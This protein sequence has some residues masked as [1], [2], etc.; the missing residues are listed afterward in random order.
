MPALRILCIESIPLDK[1]PSFF[2]SSLRLRWEIKRFSRQVR[3]LGGMVWWDRDRLD[4]VVMS[5]CY[6]GD[7]EDKVVD[8]LLGGFG[9]V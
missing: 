2:F 6:L 4:W 7:D 5:R 1:D 8:P 3:E 9:L